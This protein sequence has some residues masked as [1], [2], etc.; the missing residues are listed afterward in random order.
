MSRVYSV[1]CAYSTVRSA[2]T[3]QYTVCVSS[4]VTVCVAATVRAV[5]L[6]SGNFSITITITI[7]IA[8]GATIIVGLGLR[9]G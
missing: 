9:V 2:R 5:V 3:V 6:D 8:I 7:T 1:R 4:P